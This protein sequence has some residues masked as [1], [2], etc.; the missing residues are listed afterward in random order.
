[1]DRVVHSSV[2]SLFL[3]FFLPLLAQLQAKNRGRDDKACLVYAPSATPREATRPSSAAASGG[4]RR[5]AASAGVATHLLL[6]LLLKYPAVSPPSSPKKSS[7]TDSSAP[8]SPDVQ[9]QGHTNLF[10]GLRT[11][12]QHRGGAPSRRCAVCGKLQ[13]AGARGSSYGSS[14][15]ATAST[16][17]CS[18]ERQRRQRDRVLQLGTEKQRRKGNRFRVECVA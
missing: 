11:T 8:S 14:R 16:P 17:T 6:R 9:L 12:L 4:K 13:G 3:Q 10:D 15:L 18:S 5:G 2:S 7:G 1:M